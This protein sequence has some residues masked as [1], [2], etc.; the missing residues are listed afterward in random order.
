[1]FDY[2]S[3]EDFDAPFPSFLENVTDDKA[4]FAAFDKIDGYPLSHEIAPG[5][6][7]G[8]QGAAGILMPFENTPTA[9]FGVLEQLR[10]RNISLIICCS[11]E[12]DIG[13]VF[14]NEG[15]QYV[16]AKL[17]DGDGE[18]KATSCPRFCE[19]LQ[20][21]MPLV[22]AMQAKGNSILVHCNSGCHRSASIAAAILM[23][24]QKLRGPEGLAAVFRGMVRAR[25]VLRPSFWPL[26]QSDAFGDWLQRLQCHP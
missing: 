26:L 18:G 16:C 19:I 15:I 5:L 14:V 24:Q 2:P 21:A 11:E 20:K 17:D 12:E 10:A 9:R 8:A 13:A 3:A 4:I 22:A 6:W 23:A 25:V 1:M 7:V